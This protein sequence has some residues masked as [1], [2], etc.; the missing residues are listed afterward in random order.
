MDLVLLT[1]L[2]FFFFIIR[3][4]FIVPV[5]RSRTSSEP[6]RIKNNGSDVTRVHCNGDSVDDPRSG[7][8]LHWIQGASFSRLSRHLACAQQ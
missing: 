1:S 3:L 8:R 7:R 6:K 2:F 4:H 5:R